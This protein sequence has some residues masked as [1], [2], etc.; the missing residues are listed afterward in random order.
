MVN[1]QDAAAQA[2]EQSVTVV[3]DLDVPTWWSA[4]L[5]LLSALEC[6]RDITDKMRRGQTDSV[7][8]AYRKLSKVYV[9]EELDPALP[10]VAA[11]LTILRDSGWPEIELSAASE[12]ELQAEIKRG[13][14][15]YALIRNI[16]EMCGPLPD[17][18]VGQPELDQ[19]ITAWLWR[20]IVEGGLS[21]QAVGSAAEAENIYIRSESMPGTSATARHKARNEWTNRHT[22]G[23]RGK[24]SAGSALALE[25]LVAAT[26]EALPS[27]QPRLAS[28]SE[29]WES[30]AGILD[31]LLSPRLADAT[32]RRLS[33]R[34]GAAEL[35]EY[36]LTALPI[37]AG[38]LSAGEN[39]LL[40]AVTGSG[41]SLL[42]QICAAH[43]V[44]R[45]ERGYPG[46]R[47]I[48]ALPLK[49]LVNDVVREMKE[50]F[51]NAGLNYRVLGGS[52][53]YPENDEDLACG[54]YEVAVMIYETL[55]QYIASGRNP[56][57]GCG[58][59][60]VDELQFLSA[61]ERG[62]KLES[63]ITKVQLGYPTLPIVS[64]SAVMDPQS[65][66]DVAGWLNVDAA[67][68]EELHDDRRPVPLDVRAYDGQRWRLLED[69][70]VVASAASTT[71][72]TEGQ[73]DLGATLA[74]WEA[75]AQDGRH[76]NIIAQAVSGGSRLAP[77]LVVRLL[78][79][80]ASRHIVV[81]TRS[82][83][84]ARQLCGAIQS[85]LDEEFTAL[86]RT[87]RNNPWVMGR[88]RDP[89]L[90][91]GVAASRAE[92]L[93]RT[94]PHGARVD[95]EAGLRSGC[96]YH[97]RQL[98]RPLREM[99]EREFRDGLLRVLVT[100]DTMSVGVNL[101]IDVCVIASTTIATGGP[102][103]EVRALMAGEVKNK[104]GRAGRLGLA[105]HGD[106]WILTE[107]PTWLDRQ[108]IPEEKPLIPQ[109][110]TCDGVWERY[111]LA[112]GVGSS[113]ESRLTETAFEALVIQDLSS[114]STFHG[115]S[116]G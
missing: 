51:A 24:R 48:I 92:Q 85:A 100:T 50:W 14:L 91:P 33:A 114:T 29:T 112:A 74:K 66:A 107:D 56:L 49:T 4:W 47:A 59:L 79:E 3:Q 61:D 105:R 101:P 39:T 60:V 64:I 89:A 6:A 53:D 109:L 9:G 63:L 115:S 80:E 111:V 57:R 102:Y 21:R 90:P 36:Q 7:R 35:S 65:R 68:A 46:Q 44:S 10:A 19:R 13:Y 81:Y 87:G 71:E 45:R 54:R 67:V 88:Y 58:V 93:S 40:S 84:A 8:T 41:K 16:L 76:Q 98:T 110:S 18:D 94:A 96:M 1:S 75:S 42:G 11:G 106:A 83:T 62:A 5:D 37:L 103:G 86:R 17:R 72:G 2:T 55:D 113:V 73:L 78:E 31:Q 22:A 28:S 12:P 69:T 99:V 15:M 25:Q 26:A 77:A 116:P 43:I 34:T 70:S 82:R 32:R 52:R 95:L 20:R 104:A 97:T 38:A 108:L 30:G 27:S 23:R